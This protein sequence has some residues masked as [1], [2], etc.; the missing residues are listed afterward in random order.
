MTTAPEC[1]AKAKEKITQA[2]QDKRHRRK[3]LSAAEAWLFLAER[4]DESDHV[5]LASKVGD[6]FDTDHHRAV[7]DKAE[8]CCRL[9]GGVNDTVAMQRLGDLAD[10]DTA[11]ADK[12][13]ADEPQ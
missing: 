13:A 11:E 4:L 2:T 7:R 8:R 6:D 12:R 10:E 5:T 1:R 9:A 3:L